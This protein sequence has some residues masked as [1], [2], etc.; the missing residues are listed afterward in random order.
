[1]R[2]CAYNLLGM[3][4]FMA[5]CHAGIPEFIQFQGRLIDAATNR[6]VQGVISKQIKFTFRKVLAGDNPGEFVGST[7]TANN[8]SIREGVFSVLLPVKAMGVEFNDPLGIEVEVGSANIGFQPLRSVPYAFTSKNALQ[9]GGLA[10]SQYSLSSHIH[11]SAG[12]KSFTVDGTGANLLDNDPQLN[13]IN[14]AG[15]EVFR[16]SAKGDLSRLNSIDAIGAIETEESFRIVNQA[17][18]SVFVANKNGDVVIARDLSIAANSVLG[19]L[20]VSG[21]TRLAQ[22]LING[23][24]SFG[25]TAKIFAKPDEETPNVIGQAHR[26]E[27]HLTSP[28]FTKLESL[29]NGST[30]TAALHTHSFGAGDIT[31]NAIANDAVESRHIEDGTISNAD[32]ADDA[33]I[34]DSKLAVISTAG[35]ITTAALPA[36]V[37]FKNS[38]N[39]FGSGF[40][41][42]NISKLQSTNFFDAVRAKKFTVTSTSSAV[43]VNFLEVSDLNSEFRWTLDGN[44]TLSFKRVVAGVGEQTRLEIKTEG[45]KTFIRTQNVEF[46]GDPNLISGAVIQNGSIQGVDIAAGTINTTKI[47]AGAITAAKIAD[48]AITTVKI[49]NEAVTADKIADGEITSAKIQ[50]GAITADKIADTSITSAKIQNGVITGAKIQDGAVTSA[51]IADGVI[52]TAKIAAN[53]VQANNIVDGA[54]TSAKL[55]NGAVLN[56][57][58]DSTVLTN[59]QLPISVTLASATTPHVTLNAQNS[60]STFLKMVMNQTTASNSSN[61]GLILQNTASDAQSQ[62]NISLNLDGSISMKSSALSR[63]VTLEPAVLA[64]MF[65]IGKSG[66][67]SACTLGT[68]YKIVGN[69]SAATNGTGFCMEPKG[70][71]EN[72]NSAIVTCNSDG[73]EL[74]KVDDYRKACE[75][76]VISNDGTVYM[77]SDLVHDGTNL[78]N[79]TFQATAAGCS[80]SNYTITTNTVTT[81]QR[82]GCCINP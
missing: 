49:A 42:A 44:G 46:Q 29:V 6:P 7:H 53:A 24:L 73:A 76:N 26:F 15:S 41:V 34:A 1:M 21:D 40:D 25:P 68:N 80:A 71:N 47:Q 78:L 75:A 2:F 13:V 35:K 8:V 28:L 23:S 27:D 12:G 74:C 63:A 66:N 57:N 45:T 20:Q 50:N 61:P 43:G 77:A 65:G 79:L 10:A 67:P 52:T 22:V 4:L 3:L 31:S 54:V 39:V 19:S 30:V 72:Y 70:S 38:S 81:T 11:T 36:E 48:G 69:T 32:I 18:E 55:A 9:L 16:V 37:A 82:F 5:A 33:A 17:S 60:S 51:E 58:L 62:E 56:K 14:G 59:R 64:I